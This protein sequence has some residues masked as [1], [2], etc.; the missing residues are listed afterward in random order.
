MK[1]H[2]LPPDHPATLTR[3]LQRQQTAFLSF[4]RPSAGLQSAASTT[5]EQRP[6]SNHFR[7]LPTTYLPPRDTSSD[8]NLQLPPSPSHT[9][10]ATNRYSH[11][12]NQRTLLHMQHHHPPPDHP[13]TLT[14]YLQR[15]QTA[16]LSF[17]KPSAGQ[18]PAP[19]TTSEQ[20]PSSNLFRALP[21]TYLPPQ[22][23]SSDNNL[24]LPATTP[25]PQPYICSNKQ[26]V[27]RPALP[28][29]ATTNQ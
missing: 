27:Q 8:N 19:S 29:H 10:A 1:Q 28:Q 15:Q 17:F 7:A 18:Q 11:D 21:I 16:F 2:H 14:R 6:S 9:A 3:Y 24:Q 25:P 5:S 22:D 12:Y 20:P 23:T 4:F 26:T 13:A